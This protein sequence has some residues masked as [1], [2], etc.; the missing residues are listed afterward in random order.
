MT[1]QFDEGVLGIVHE[2]GGPDTP[3]A[4]GNQVPPELVEYFI[5]N[6]GREPDHSILCTLPTAQHSPPLGDVT[7]TKAK[8]G[9]IEITNVAPTKAI[10][11]TKIFLGFMIPSSLFK[12]LTQS[13]E[14]FT[15]SIEG[16][17]QFNVTLSIY[18]PP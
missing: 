13:I 15:Q 9:A 10:I 2:Y 3:E 16:L 7:V 1:L 6:G 17:P 14:K 18:P 12:G 11:M 5:V 8:A 4:I